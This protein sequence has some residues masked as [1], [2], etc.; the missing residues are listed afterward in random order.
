V[1][2]R[3]AT[4]SSIPPRTRRKL[5]DQVDLLSVTS[6]AQRQPGS[7]RLPGDGVGQL[8]RSSHLHAGS[9][10]HIIPGFQACNFSHAIT[11]YPA[12]AGRTIAVYQHDAEPWTL[13]R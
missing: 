13:R 10:H 6:D 7:G 4:D 9:P 3:E 8:A 2:A 11:D 5:G 1:F 12:D